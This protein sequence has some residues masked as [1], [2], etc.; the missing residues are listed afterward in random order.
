MKIENST[1]LRQL[2][3]QADPGSTAKL[4]LL[5]DGREMS[6][7]AILGERP[8]E[9]R[10][11]RQSSWTKYIFRRDSDSLSQS[12]FIVGRSHLQIYTWQLA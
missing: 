11:V 12:D 8:K 7:S 2:V 9:R 5:R 1:Q 10:P 3:A 6:I 4:N